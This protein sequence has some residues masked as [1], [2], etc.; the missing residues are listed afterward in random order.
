[1]LPGQQENINRRSPTRV[2]AT[3]P[4]LPQPG[5]YQSRRFEVTQCG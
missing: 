5:L 3:V 4:K 1:M 2:A